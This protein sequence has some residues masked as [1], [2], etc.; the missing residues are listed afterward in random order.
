[1]RI[2]IYSANFAP[3][4]VGIGKYSGEMASWLTDRGH[5]VRVVAAPPYYP[6]WKRHPDYSRFGYRREQWRGMLVWRAP[7]WVPQTPAGLKRVLHLLSFAVTSFPVVLWQIFWRPDVVITVAPAFLCAPAGWLTAR[8]SRAQAWLHI[9][10]FEIDIAFKIG[11]LKSRLLQRIVLGMERWML[12]RFDS[13]SSISYRMVERLI[14]KGV[15]KERTRFFPNWVDISHISPRRDGSAYRTQLGIAPDAVVALYSGTLGAKQGLLLIPAAAALLAS[16]RDI[17]FV[18]CGDGVMKPQLALASEG[19]P[20]IRLLDLQPFDRLGDL[21]CMADIHLLP[22]SDDAADL[23]LPSKLSAMLASGRPVVA[24]CRAGT[25]LETVVSQ[26]GLV[27][28]PGDPAALA[29]AV[30]RLADDPKGRLHLGR[31]ARAWAEANVE[32]DA[33]LGKFFGPLDHAGHAD[34]SQGDGNFM[35]EGPDVDAAVESVARVE[36]PSALA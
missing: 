9:Q 20:N 18:I 19:M 6:D 2:L 26:C 5:S 25:E 32:R 28:P 30:V 10:D 36:D 11:V 35:S 31:C 29:A 16:R 23:V 12:R 7:L 27:V 22:Q 33:V 15:P 34:K 3:E 17:V 1:M 14:N 8:L 4:P 24:T 13:V 21:L